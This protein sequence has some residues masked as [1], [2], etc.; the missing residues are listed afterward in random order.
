MN[1]KGKSVLFSALLF[2]SVP[3]LLRILQ[4]RNGFGIDDWNSNFQ[5][6][7]VLRL[8]S[9]MYGVIAAYLYKY[10]FKQWV[11]YKNASLILALIVVAGLTFYSRTSASKHNML[12]LA[13]YQ[14]NLESL[15]TFFAL[16]Y[17]SQLKFTKIKL[18]AFAF[19]FISIISYSMYLLNLTPVQGI[20]IPMTMKL[21]GLKTSAGS[22]AMLFQY[23]IFWGYVI[24]CSYLL[25]KF[26]EKPMMDLRDKFKV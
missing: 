9:L 3:L 25:Y 22:F 8:D 19:T 4:Y 1:H 2:I 5:K 20:L 24:G 15:A 21:L 11:A 17:C 13:V 18:W 14:Y 10:K 16:P 26:F 12:F 23:F 7:V 6:I